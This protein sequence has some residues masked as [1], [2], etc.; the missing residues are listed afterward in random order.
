MP[1]RGQISAL[2]Q[3]IAPSR[4]EGDSAEP[5]IEESVPLRD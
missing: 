1:V 3:H 2:F 5:A 4:S